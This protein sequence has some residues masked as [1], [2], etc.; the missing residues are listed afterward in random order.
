MLKN[1][2]K[3]PTLMKTN[4]KKA[5]TVKK[6]IVSKNQKSISKV[7]S[8]LYLTHFSRIKKNQRQIFI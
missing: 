8:Y 4:V 2:P 1:K 7:F 5:T 6:K 3:A